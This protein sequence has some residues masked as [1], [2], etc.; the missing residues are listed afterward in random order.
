MIF[1]TVLFNQLRSGG[2]KFVL[3]KIRRLS[4]WGT[5]TGEMI[6][7]WVSGA[8]ATEVNTI[9]TITAK[10]SKLSDKSRNK[11]DTNPDQDSPLTS[12]GTLRILG[13]RRR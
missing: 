3:R 4:T 2:E 1:L 12:L 6:F 11:M 9:P 10:I 8:A 5:S 13:K 7:Q